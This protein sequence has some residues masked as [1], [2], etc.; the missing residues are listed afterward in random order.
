MTHHQFAVSFTAPHKMEE[1][2]KLAET[3]D[4]PFLDNPL[5]E[6]LSEAVA[7]YDYLLIYTPTYLGLH[8]SGENLASPFYIDFLSGKLLYR[9]QHASRKK[10]LLARAM[11]VS[12]REHPIIV[13]ATAGLG[14]DSF[15]L[16]SLGFHITLLE[17]SPIL[18]ALLTDAILRA[19]L[20]PRLLPVMKRMHL[21]KTDSITWLSKQPPADIIYLDPM[22]PERKK[23]ALSKGNMQIFHDIVGADPDAGLLLETALSCAITR[24]VVKRPRLAEPLSGIKP[25]YSLSGNSS[26]FD[27]YII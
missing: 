12:P 23:S 4:L 8:A 6:P 19:S 24:V 18:H 9:Q 20:D 27:I 26:R 21:I 14:R 1:A 15:I 10:E 7:T 13:D 25:T 16:A 17:R 22:F 5:S 3:L 2:R 11:G